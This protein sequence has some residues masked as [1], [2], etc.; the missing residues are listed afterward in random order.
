MARIDVGG[1]RV[2]QRRDS[3]E[4]L[5]V[6]DRGAWMELQA[7]QQLRILSRRKFRDL[8][9]VGLYPLVP[10]PLVDRLEI[11]Q[12]PAARE[13]RRAV[14]NRARRTS[15]ESHNAVHAEQRRKP[16]RVA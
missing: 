5:D 9:P 6:V 3:L 1:D 7:D 8:G 16:D 2:T 13:M 10:L 12:P 14:A 11:R 15:G 4:R